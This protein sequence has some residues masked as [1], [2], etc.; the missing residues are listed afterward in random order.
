MRS[1]KSA[2]VLGLLRRVKPVI[3]N[4]SLDRKRAGSDLLGKLK[5]MP[6]DLRILPA[7]APCP[8][9]WMLPAGERGER[10]ILYSHGGAYEGGSLLSSRPLAAALAQET[11]RRV[12]SYHYRLAPEHPF[13]AALEDALAVY[14]YLYREEGI[15][16]DAVALAGDSAG[17]G[18]SLALTLRL[19]ELGEPLPGGIVCLSP[20]ADL[21]GSASS[22]RTRAQDDPIIQSEGLHQSAL[23]YAAGTALSSPY[24]SPVYGDLTGFP[25]VLIQVGTNEVLL[26]DSLLLKKRLEECQVPVRLTVFDGM[27]HVFHV[28]DLPETNEALEEIRLFLDGN[29]AENI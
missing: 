6:P 24:L 18:L 10:V 11:G 13:P 7:A 22:H 26:G 4:L 14:R 23:H 25:P 29:A 27:W 2:V 20:W 19:K 16:P 5:K 28:F 3:C 8:A 21:T 12:L 15:S 1:K 9:E 17:G